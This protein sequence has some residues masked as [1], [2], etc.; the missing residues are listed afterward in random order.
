MLL[1]KIVVIGPE[2]TGKSTLCANLANHYKTAWVPEYAREYLL[3]NGMA[4]SFEN[5]LTIAQGQ[6][7]LEEKAVAAASSGKME[8]AGPRLL[9]IDTDLYVMKVWCEFVFNKCHTWIIDQ[10]VSRNY[11]LYLLCNTDLPWVQDEL[12]EYPDLET[13]EKLFRT[14]KDILINQQ[15]RWVEI[16]GNSDQRLKSALPAIDQL[17]C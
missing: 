6:I 13:R 7:G 2:S 14:Y 11:D 16:S 3:T 15:T 1:R 4:Y 17:L 5:L 8:D 10:I 12:R 9:F